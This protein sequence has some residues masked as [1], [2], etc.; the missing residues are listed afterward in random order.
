MRINRIEV[1]LVGHEW[2]NL[3]LV[4]VHTDTGLSGLGEGTM[5]PPV[6]LRR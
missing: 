1:F 3:V 6:D 2:N 5:Q 4:R